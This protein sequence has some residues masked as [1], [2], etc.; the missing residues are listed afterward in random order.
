M[1]W[2][3]IVPM[4]R[5]VIRRETTKMRHINEAGIDL[6]KSWE[7]CVLKPYQDEAG[8]WTIGWGHLIVEGENFS[9]ITSERADAILE[10]DLLQ[11]E[12]AVERLISVPLTDNQFAALVSFTF[13]LGPGAL[14][15]STLRK[16]LNRGEYQAAAEEF[17]KWCYAG[18]H[19]SA[20]L[21]KRRLEEGTLFL[22]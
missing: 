15:R 13:N 7:G 1:D 19:K 4:K 9:E 17:P 21:L 18:G 20:G 5:K 6:I 10:V 16:V 12:S 22:T 3:H 2:A 14:E 8:Y 11:A